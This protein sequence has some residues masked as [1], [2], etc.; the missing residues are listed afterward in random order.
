MGSIY[1]I[2]RNYAKHA[3]EL[4]NEVPTT[5]LVFLKTEAALR[6]FEPIDM[7]FS[8][9]TFHYEGE[10][11]LKIGRDHK[12]GEAAST[13]SI[14]S[15]AFGIDLTRRAEQSKLKD[16]G[17]PWTTSK[18]FLGSAI[19]G[20]FHSWD[21]F[22]DF[23]SLR[24]TFS[25]N[26]ELKQDGDTKDMIFDFKTIITYINSFSPLNKDDLIF[27]GTPEGVGEIKKGD[28]FSFTMKDISLTEKGI[29]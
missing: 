13:D 14:E 19:I 22:S 3:K 15:L 27:T 1:C 21:Q 11:V 4:G 20:N 25:V 10:L 7:P 23:D 9:E 2:G 18:S 5:P 29:L 12:L 16:K 17:H 28:H 26:D 6:S 24:Y 8:D